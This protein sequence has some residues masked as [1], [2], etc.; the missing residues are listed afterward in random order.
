M[1]LHKLYD[2]GACGAP[3][4]TPPTQ[5]TP[6]KCD[7][8]NLYNQ[9]ED[10][11]LIVRSDIP[12]RDPIFERNLLS[13]MRNH[14]EASRHIQDA[15]IRF[16]QTYGTSTILKSD[17]IQ[18]KAHN[19][20]TPTSYIDVVVM[21][22]KDSDKIGTILSRRQAGIL[23]YEIIPVTQQNPPYIYL[24]YWAD[25][26]WANDIESQLALFTVGSHASMHDSVVPDPQITKRDRVSNLNDS[27]LLTNI[28]KKVMFKN[29]ELM[30]A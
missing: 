23:G 24:G 13:V 17:E 22:N 20:Q 25:I 11:H 16:T 4:A 2:C 5:I 26:T 7:F 3:L 18:W 12:Y 21:L 29:T 10:T 8:C 14:F 19:M 9:F 1:I 27:K 30:G 28:I 15:T 6:V